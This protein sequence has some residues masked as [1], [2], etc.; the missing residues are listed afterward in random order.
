MVLEEDLMD[1]FLESARMHRPTL[2]GGLAE[3]I[4]GRSSVELERAQLITTQKVSNYAKFRKSTQ[5]VL[6]VPPEEA[7]SDVD[8]DQSYLSDA[9][10]NSKDYHPSLPQV[11]KKEV[12]TSSM[13]AGIGDKF[14]DSLVRQKRLD[15]DDVF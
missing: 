12:R 10:Y 11:K 15:V 14:H 5:V 4:V 6:E 9:S 13:T 1:E 2:I 7:T 8:S 3:S